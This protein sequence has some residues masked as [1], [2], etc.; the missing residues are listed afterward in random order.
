MKCVV[1]VPQVN[2]NSLVRDSDGE[3]FFSLPLNM[4]SKMLNN[5][6]KLELKSDPSLTNFQHY[7]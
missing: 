4:V 7:R 5:C 1:A 2:R 6:F 3:S